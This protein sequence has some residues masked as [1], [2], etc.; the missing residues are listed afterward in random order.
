MRWPAPTGVQAL[1]AE[2]PDGQEHEDEDQVDDSGG[3]LEEVVVVPVMN[4]PSSSMKKPETDPAEDRLDGPAPA[5]EVN[6][7]EPD[8]DHHEEAAVEQVGDV[9]GH[10]RP[11]A[12]SGSAR[13]ACG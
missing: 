11:A 1:P 3:R 2:S 7:A 5:V 10:R 13:A 4:L 9:E 12:G 6:L 8:R